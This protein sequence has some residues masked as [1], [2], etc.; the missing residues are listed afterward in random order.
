MRARP[1]FASAATLAAVGTLVASA[2]AVGCGSK[3][4]SVD[5]TPADTGVVDSGT[6][7]SVAMDTGPK[8]TGT[9]PVDS[10]AMYDVPGSLFDVEVP[11][12][13]FEGGTSAKTCYDCMTT[14]CKDE[15]GVCDADPQCRG[16]VLCLLSDCAG[17]F[18]DLGCAFGCAAM[19][20]VTSPSDPVATEALG[21]AQCVQK[22]CTSACPVPADAG[23]KTDAKSDGTSAETA[24][25]EAGGMA[26]KFQ[27]APEKAASFKVAPESIDPQVGVMLQSLRESLLSSPEISQALM[28]KY[29]H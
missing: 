3:E 11:D 10:G 29:A 16:I 18:T 8:D 1:R 13:Q 5:T 12:V 4:S 25:A 15:V 7:T 19:Y 2:F 14:K 23:P 17:S 28:D 22:N 26:F 24:I 27:Y 21:V 20:G 6:D 9:P